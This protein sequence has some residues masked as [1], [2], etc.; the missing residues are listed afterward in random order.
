MRWERQLVPRVHGVSTV[1]ITVRTTFRPLYGHLNV[2]SKINN[3]YIYVERDNEVKICAK[4]SKT[5][6][7]KTSKVYK[8]NLSMQKNILN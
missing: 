2:D 1:E 5:R 4:I 8:K 7:L 6:V 3:V